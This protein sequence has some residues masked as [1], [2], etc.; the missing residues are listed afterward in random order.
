MG[1]TAFFSMAV[2]AAVLSGDPARAQGDP[3]NSDG[4]IRADA[5]NLL[6][7]LTNPYGCDA[8]GPADN[9]PNLGPPPNLIAQT[10]VNNT[11]GEPM[12]VYACSRSDDSVQVWVNDKLVT[13]K[14]VCRAMDADCS[15]SNP[16]VLEAG[17]NRITVL[18]WE[19]VG[20]WS[21]GLSLGIP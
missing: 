7:P 19:G 5:W 16:M 13:N 18:T 8:G 14:S 10:Y 21:F 9:L 3:Y 20:G 12:C 6:F 17:I 15:E 11:T 2:I 4:W 1:R